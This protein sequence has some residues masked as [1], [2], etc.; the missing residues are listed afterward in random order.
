[1]VDNLVDNRV[2]PK[3]FSVEIRSP[4]TDRQLKIQLDLDKDQARDQSGLHWIGKDAV[5]YSTVI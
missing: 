3:G 4:V 1:M 5:S 2:V